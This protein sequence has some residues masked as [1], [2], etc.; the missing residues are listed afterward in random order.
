M[1]SQ[2]VWAILDLY[3]PV[4]TVSIVSSTRLEEPE[5]TQ[6]P[7]PSSDTGSEGE[8]DEEGEEHGLLVRGCGRACWAHEAPCKWQQGAW[9]WH[10]NLLSSVSPPL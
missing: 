8:H 5:G 2:N 10:C 3:G 9:A 4:R 6:P 1:P 7:S